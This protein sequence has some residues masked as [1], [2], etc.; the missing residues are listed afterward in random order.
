MPMLERLT[1]AGR[2]FIKC[3]S[4]RGSTLQCNRIKGF[5]IYVDIRNFGA[6]VSSILLTA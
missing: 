5:L 6:L 2:E 1:L 3:Y 4:S